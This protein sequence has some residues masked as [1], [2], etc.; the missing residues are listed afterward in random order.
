MIKLLMTWDIKAGKEAE[1][2]EFVTREFTPELMKLGIQPT[3]AWYTVVGNGPQVVAGGI[4]KDRDTMITIL[5]SKEWE[6]LESKLLDYVSNY[7][8]KVVRATGQF[9]L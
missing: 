2:M 5:E 6:G 7:N 9:Q 3:E 1:Y 4:T 8:Y